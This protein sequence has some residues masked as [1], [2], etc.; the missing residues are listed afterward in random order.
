MNNKFRLHPQM[1]IGVIIIIFGVLFTLDNMGIIN[2]AGYYLR[3]WPVAIILIGLLKVVSPAHRGERV[4]GV[5]VGGIGTLLLLWTLHTLS[6][7]IWN[8]WPLVLV[9]FGA[10]MLFGRHKHPEEF[11]SMRKEKI[12][13][14]FFQQFV[15]MSGTH[16]QYTTN[17]FQ[18][19]D[20]TAIMGGTQLDLRQAQMAADSAIIS[21]FAFW[22]GAEI[23]VPDTWNVLLEGTPI[24][25]GF[26]IK[27]LPQK[28]PDA[29]RLIIRGY[30]IM[31]GVEVKN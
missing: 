14:P 18:G 12:A 2:D 21:V 10:K 6:F 15:F 30:A 13:D 16:Q 7:S 24:M 25:G 27:T 29:K 20:I 31:G 19:G 5:I 9:F 4:A 11:W 28:N 8:L 1:V 3:F 22:G 23:L 17:D 26:D